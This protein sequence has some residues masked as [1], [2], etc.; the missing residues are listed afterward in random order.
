MEFTD[1]LRLSIAGDHAPGT[2]KSR[3]IALLDTHYAHCGQIHF[4]SMHI[5]YTFTAKKQ[6]IKC[7]MAACTASISH[8]EI[9]AAP[10]KH[11]TYANA[12][13]YGR[14]E[15]V[16]LTIPAPFT[17]QLQPVSS[18]HPEVDFLLQTSGG[19]EISI[20]IRLIVRGVRTIIS[21]VKSGFWSA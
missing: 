20:E 19:F 17:A 21:P 16:V 7:G 10:V 1:V 15:T 5:T 4:H 12:M 14:Q 11:V 8:S 2:R 6:F 13:T 3:I 9:M 18:N